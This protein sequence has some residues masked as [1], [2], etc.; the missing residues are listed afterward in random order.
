[1]SAQHKI[2]P[3]LW[4]DG[5]AEEAARLYTSVFPDS[6]I[7][8]LQRST[9]DWPGGKA[10]GVILVE[11]TLA[12]FPCQALNGGPHVTFNDAIS[13]SV[14][15]KDQ[16]EVD[17]Y[18]DALTADGGKPVMCGWLKDK[19]GVSWQIVPDALIAMMRDPDRAKAG[20]VMQAMMQMVKLD[21][22]GLKQ[23]FDGK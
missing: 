9:S 6:R 22:A 11:F 14:S 5:R 12:G 23:A 19:F 4:F 8:Q 3:C 16:G 15:C 1:M 2:T 20:R 7:D 18:W 21:I 13:L 10:G 17:R